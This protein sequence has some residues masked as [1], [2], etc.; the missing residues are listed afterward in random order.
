M[1]LKRHTLLVVDDEPDNL[2]LFRLALK[3][4]PL[5]KEVMTLP[6][7]PQALRY[8][9]RCQVGGNP[10]CPFPSLMFLDLKMPG[11][12]GLQVLKHIRAEEVMKRIPVIMFTTSREEKDIAASYDLGANSFIRKSVDYDVFCHQLE[13]IIEYWLVTNELPF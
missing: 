3:W 9:Q 10:A 8:L 7:G 13:G 5:I 6:E 12:N 4:H 11:M 2:K 1:R